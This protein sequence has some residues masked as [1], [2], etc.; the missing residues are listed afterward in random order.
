MELPN[1]AKLLM[2]G[3]N[4]AN[5]ATLMPDG[6]PQITTTWVDR[7]GDIVIINTTK[8]RVKTHNVERDPRIAISV[9]SM[10]D[11]YDAVYLRGRVVEIRT[12][13]AEEHVDKLAQKYLGTNYREHGDRVMLLIE[14]LKIHLQKP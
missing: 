8:G 5:V 10:Q 7:E 4:F 11:P 3:K 13:G 2:D 12:E 14:P 6:S 9:F 1:K